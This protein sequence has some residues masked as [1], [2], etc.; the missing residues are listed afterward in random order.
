VVEEITGWSFGANIYKGFLGLLDDLATDIDPDTGTTTIADYLPFAYDW[1]YSVFDVAT[2]P[3]QYENETKLLKEELLRLADG[4]H[5]GKVTIIA[6]SNGGLVA[7][8]LL[9]EYGD[10]ELEGLIDKVV[11]IGTPQLGTPKGISALLHGQ[12]MEGFGDLFTQDAVLRNTILNMPGTYTLLPSTRYLDEVADDPLIRVANGF[13]LSVY[14]GISNRSQLNALLLDTQNAVGPNPSIREPIQLN[15]T[16]LAEAL[17]EQAILDVWRPPAGVEVY[18]V[19]GTG[20]PTPAALH[21]KVVPAV[22]C[23]NAAAVFISTQC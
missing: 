10:N 3:V 16:L 19:A 8:A 2:Q 21:Y 14:D 12:V 7:K 22:K 18:E 6:H 5:T 13:D 9:H 1:R 20:I 15:E 23:P 17:A 4:S 11:M